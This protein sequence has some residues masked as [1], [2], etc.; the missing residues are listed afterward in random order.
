MTLILSCDKGII[1]AWSLRSFHSTDVL[2]FSF[3]LIVLH[4]LSGAAHVL[5]LYV[6]HSPFVRDEPALTLPAAAFCLCVKMFSGS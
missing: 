5:P 6:L 2:F 3:L 4:E 1:L